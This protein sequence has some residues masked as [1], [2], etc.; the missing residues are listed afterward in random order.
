MKKY[1]LILFCVG[2]IGCEG[3]QPR[4]PVKVKTGSF[5]KESAERS[6]KLLALE[7]K[8]IQDII[9]N[10]SLHSYQSSAAGSWFYYDEQVTADTPMPL[11]DDLVTMSY[12]VVS[13]AN[14]TIYSMEDIGVIKY[15]VDKQELFPGLRNS[16][17]LLKEKETA[18]FYFPSSL[19][20][21]YH[22]DNN[23]IGT[24]VPIKSTISI[25]KIEK[26]QDSI[27]N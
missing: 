12:N 9:E 6:K 19:A 1:W 24:N 3:P 26:Q 23:K 17:K 8:M 13:L 11:P 14:D 18:T 27:Q 2:F 15:K 25:F 7:E 20:Y 4:R 5:M 22:G 16:V 21:G 10:D